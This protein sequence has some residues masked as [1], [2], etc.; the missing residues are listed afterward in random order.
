MPSPLEDHRRSDDRPEADDLRKLS[1]ELRSFVGLDVGIGDDSLL[2]NREARCRGV[3]QRPRVQLAE[4][5]EALSDIRTDVDESIV[6]NEHHADDVA[7]EQPL[8]SSG[9]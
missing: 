6:A 7:G 8:D 1:G 9:G 3:L 2:D 5:V 4:L